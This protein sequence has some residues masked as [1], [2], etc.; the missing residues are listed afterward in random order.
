MRLTEDRH[1]I[2]Q[3]RMS[4]SRAQ[5]QSYLT[6]WDTSISIDKQLYDLS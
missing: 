5:H 4:P 1:I 3:D 2:I 6:D